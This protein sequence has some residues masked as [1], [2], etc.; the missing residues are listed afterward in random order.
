MSRGGREG[1]IADIRRVV[2][3]STRARE[4]GNATGHQAACRDIVVD[5]G[6]ACD[7]DWQ[8]I[9]ER[10]TARHRSSR[11]LG[12]QVAPGTERIEDRRR[13]PSVSG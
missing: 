13:E 5:S 10:L 6:Y 12:S 4:R 11:I 7:T 3:G 9:E 2:T 1:M 8:R